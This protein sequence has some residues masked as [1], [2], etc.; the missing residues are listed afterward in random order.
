MDVAPSSPGGSVPLGEA[1]ACPCSL[2]ACDLVTH[3][4]LQVLGYKEAPGEHPAWWGNNFSFVP[5]LWNWNPMKSHRDGAGCHH[6]GDV[7]VRVQPASAS[8]GAGFAM[9]S[10]SRGALQHNVTALHPGDPFYPAHG[11][12]ETFASGVPRPLLRGYSDL[13][14]GGTQIFAVGVLDAA[15]ITAALLAPGQVD[16]SPS[17]TWRFVTHFVEYV[18]ATLEHER[19]K[20][21]ASFVPFVTTTVI[22]GGNACGSSTALAGVTVVSFQNYNG[23]RGAVA[24]DSAGVISCAK[25]YRKPVV[26]MGAMDRSTVP[27]SAVCE[28]LFEAYGQAAMLIPAHPRIGIVLGFR[29][30]NGLVIGAD[31]LLGPGGVPRGGLVY[32]NGTWYSAAEREC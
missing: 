24:G 1:C 3:W 14:L 9:Y 17:D 26:L 16:T 21:N 20:S 11:D 2:E 32:P 19:V 28:C 13:C 31:V 8:A 6:L 23:N 4:A 12:N 22:P 30:G 18:N 29:A 10:S 27:Q 7:T 15:D 25:R 5:P